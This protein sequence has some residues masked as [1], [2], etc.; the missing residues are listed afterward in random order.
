[1]DIAEKKATCIVDS[2]KVL[3]ERLRPL[4]RDLGQPTP[5]D[6]SPAKLAPEEML[7][8]HADRLARIHGMV[9]HALETINDILK[10]LES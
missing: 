5:V 10:R 1:M 6:L 4:L 3:E 8:P 7:V 2:A 9:G